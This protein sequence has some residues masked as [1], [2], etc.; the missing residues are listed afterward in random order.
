MGKVMTPVIELYISEIYPLKNNT[1]LVGA[2][3]NIDNGIFLVEPTGKFTKILPN[4][5]FSFGIHSFGIH[6]FYDKAN[7]CWVV[8]TRHGHGNEI[9]RGKVRFKCLW[10]EEPA[11]KKACYEYYENSEI[12]NR[13]RFE[14]HVAYLEVDLEDLSEQAKLF[15]PKKIIN[16]L[17]NVK[18]TGNYSLL[19]MD[20]N[21]AEVIEFTCPINVSDVCFSHDGTTILAYSEE[22]FVIID[23]PLL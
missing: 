5:A 1:W 23:N 2:K 15:I 6:C 14:D 13:H 16:G 20:L 7:H 17:K 10:R 9:G 4:R 19:V 8:G 11:S 12:F 18:S 21:T 22:G 3:E